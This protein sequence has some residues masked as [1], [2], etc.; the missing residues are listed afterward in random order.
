MTTPTTFW[1]LAGVSYVQVGSI[2]DVPSVPV[3][4]FSYLDGFAADF[5]R[6]ERSIDGFLGKNKGNAPSMN[7]LFCF[8]METSNKRMTDRPCVTCSSLL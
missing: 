7:G 3:I 4:F 8:A 1:R 2:N 6:G 5:P